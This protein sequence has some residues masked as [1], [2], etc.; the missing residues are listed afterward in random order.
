MSLIQ[1]IK[2]YNT[3]WNF[4][5]YILN[6]QFF[7]G[8][9]DITNKCNLHCTHC[10]WWRQKK[11][12]DLDDDQMIVFMKKLR[13]KGLRVIYLLGGEPLLRPKVVVAASKIFDYVMIFTN[14]TLGYIPLKN[15]LFSLSIDGP[16]SVHDNLRGKGIFKKVTRILDEQDEKVMIHITVCESNR[17]HL[18][19]TVENFVYRENV[20][21]IYFCFY[22]PSVSQCDDNKEAIPLKDRDK[23]VDTIVGLRREYGEKIFFTERVG[24]YVKTTGGLDQWNSL[25]KC[26]TKHLF[27][28]YAADG[29]YKYHCAYGSEADCAQC[30]CS[31]VPLI[32]SLIDGDFE[33]CAMAYKSYWN[34][35]FFNNTILKTILKLKFPSSRIQPSGTNGI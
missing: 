10:Y 29:Q 1:T 23:V 32:H 13:K 30:G 26:I 35:P 15:G 6:E 31:Q 18:R 2:R 8:G 5:N 22:C 24:Y 7:G 33:T 28:F 34:M 9:L 4:P 11:N 14:G 20:R 19:E 3:A 25:K 12:P 21:G 17:F 16:E 27:E